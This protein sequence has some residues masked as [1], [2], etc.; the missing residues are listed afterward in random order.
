M[1]TLTAD[2]PFWD[3][4]A[5]K[6]AQKPVDD[7]AAFER[8]K[9]LTRERLRAD[10]TVFE[11]GCGTGSLALELASAAGH[12]HAM[13]V[14]AEMIRIANEKKA[15]LGAKN[16]TFHRGTLEA[17]TPADL[18]QVDEVWAF[19]ILH[20]VDDRRRTLEALFAR[21]K[22]GGTLVSSNVCL[23]DSWV[24]FG[25]L[26]TV[27]RWLGKAPRVHIYGRLTI[28]R[29]LRDVGFIDVEEKNVGADPK[30]AF[31]LARRP[32]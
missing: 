11:I 9:A 16:V 5:E 15:T 31:I 3:R 1:Q 8:K 22:P 32:L 30:V 2:E 12:I 27:M 17:G 24:P 21:L 7:P 10:S 4:I 26:I 29:E 20:L 23:G 14:S 18:G 19:S 25:S 28:L 6:Y 13:D